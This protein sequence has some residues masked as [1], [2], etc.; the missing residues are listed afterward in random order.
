VQGSLRQVF[1]VWGL[2][3]E[4]GLD[5]GLPW[6]DRNDLPS[7]LALWL[8][9]LGLSVQFLPV[10]QKQLNG[11]VERS[12]GTGQRWCEP[13]TCRTASEL[14]ARLET[15]DRIQR[16]EYPSFPAGPRLVVFPQLR[17]VRRP[18]SRAWEEACWD[19]GRAQQYLSGHAVV[20]QANQQGQ[21]AVYNHR[22]S[23]GAKQRGQRV[24]AYYDPG[25]GEWVFTLEQTGQQLR[26]YRAWEITRERILEQRVSS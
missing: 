17:Q 14:Q 9:G 23:V 1:G 7:A 11:V 20:R 8:V 22:Y 6:G 13:Q 12:Q 15:M 24:L 25:A 2:P 21:V 16:E 10:G 26:R 4:V 18:Y 5:N 3:D 19:L